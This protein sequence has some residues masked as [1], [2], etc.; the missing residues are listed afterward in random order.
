MFGYVTPLKPELK[1]KD[2]YTFKSYYCGLCFHIKDKLGNIPRLALNYDM[3]FLG[4]LLDSISD[5]HTKLENKRC[6]IHFTKKKP[7]VVNNQALSYAAEINLSLF[8]YKLLDD[9]EDDKNILSKLGTVILNPYK[10]KFTPAVTDI[11]III[12]DKLKE[13][14]V[15]EKE[16]NFDFI[17][18]ISDPFSHIVG[19]LL[20]EY[21]YEISEDNSSTR[22]LLYTLGYNLGKWIYLIDALDDL[23]DDMK[24][25]KFNPISY[26][27]NNT[28]K[29]FKDFLQEI[30]PRIEFSILNCSKS[31]SDVTLKLPIK[32]NRDILLNII[33][34]GMM[35]KY[36]K[37][38]TNCDNCNVRSE[39]N[40]ESI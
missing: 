37:V 30:K 12:K 7:V 20:M 13:L 24:S 2:Y 18:E 27:F 14:T 3:T 26:L 11:N 35:D 32:K 21:P 4:L 36:I 19:T 34:L 17:D 6:L 5:N 16:K 25:N 38:S 40:H 39:F 22:N 1:I 10:K 8:Y 23:E 15:L 29:N 28:N 31:C 9:Y 33:N